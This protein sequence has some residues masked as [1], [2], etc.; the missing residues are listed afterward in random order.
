[1]GAVSSEVWPFLSP[2]SPLCRPAVIDGIEKKENP[3][4][5]CGQVKVCTSGGLCALHAPVGSVKRELYWRNH[6]DKQRLEV[7]HAQAMQQEQDEMKSSFSALLRETFE[8]EA[9]SVDGEKQTPWGM[10]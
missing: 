9:V 6:V 4:T 7:R 5:I 2:P 8:D 3:D 1:M 10:P